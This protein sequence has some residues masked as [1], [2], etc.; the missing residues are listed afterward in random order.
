MVERYSFQSGPVK[1]LV[2]GW[3]EY[4]KPGE[5]NKISIVAEDVSNHVF[6]HEKD[7]FLTDSMAFWSAAMNSGPSS[8]AWRR[9]DFGD[10]SRYE[11]LVTE[12]SRVLGHE[13]S[14]AMPYRTFSC[15][16]KNILLYVRHRTE[17]AVCEVENDRD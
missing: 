2:P 5:E 6:K 14:D 4:A 1:W 8:I 16:S 7:I 15:C 9:A 11:L 12:V 10:D 13:T 3:R 17:G